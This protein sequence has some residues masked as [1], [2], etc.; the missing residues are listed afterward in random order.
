[1]TDARKPVLWLHSHFLLPMGGTKFI[2]EVT[3]RLAERRPVE[4]M[5]E[6]ASPLWRE[7]YAEA[8][9]PLREIGG[10][11]STSMAYW[12]ALPVLPAPGTARAVAAAAADAAAIVSS[13]FP[14]HWVGRTPAERTASGT[15][16]CAS[17][18]SRSSTTAR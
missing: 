5:V 17:S 13:F 16:T 18:R 15:C 8:G 9:V 1:M 4:V 12:L 11:T 7:R 14:M 6:G 2:F 10:A 3:R